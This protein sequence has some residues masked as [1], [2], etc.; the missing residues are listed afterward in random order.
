MA[1]PDETRLPIEEK[2]T[3]IKN[4]DDIIGLIQDE[5]KKLNLTEFTK[6]CISSS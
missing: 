3:A 6:P 4:L 1:K 5:V 2:R